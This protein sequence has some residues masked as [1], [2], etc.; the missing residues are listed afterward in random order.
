[1]THTE[2]IQEISQFLKTIN[3]ER[4]VS[5]HTSRAY[6]SDLDHFALFWQELLAREPLPLSLKNLNFIKNDQ[7]TPLAY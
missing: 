2:F 7:K 6:E 4:N 5:I 1:M 3:V